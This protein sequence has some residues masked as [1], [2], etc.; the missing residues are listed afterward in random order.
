MKEILSVSGCGGKI[1]KKQMDKMVEIQQ[2]SWI[3]FHHQKVIMED[4]LECTIISM[5]TEPILYMYF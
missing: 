5:Y 2:N 4:G 3:D 1:E